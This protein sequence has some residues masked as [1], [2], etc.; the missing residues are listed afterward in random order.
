MNTNF[1][2]MKIPL[3]EL[4]VLVIVLIIFFCI[5]IFSFI[6]KLVLRKKLNWL[7]KRIIFLEGKVD[8]KISTNN[9]LNKNL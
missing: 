1:I 9:D 5:T 4:A 8:S 6:L 7:E 2:T 3:D